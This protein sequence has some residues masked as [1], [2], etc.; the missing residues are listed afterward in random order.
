MKMCL[1]LFASALSV[2]V[3]SG[4]YADDLPRAVVSNLAAIE[5]LLAQVPDGANWQSLRPDLQ[6]SFRGRALLLLDQDRQSW[7]LTGLQQKL[8]K[9]FND[10]T[11][12]MTEN[13]DRILSVTFAPELPGGFKMA[14]DVSSAELKRLLIRIYLAITDDRG[15][16]LYN[17]PDFMGWD[18]M[19]IKEL[20]LL[21][22]EH[23]RAIAT[24]LRLTEDGLRGLPDD[25]LSALERALRDKSY[26]TT[27][28][29]KNFDRPAVGI[30]GSMNFSNLYALDPQKRPFTNDTE[31]LDAYNASMFSEFREVN[32]GTLDAFMY[33][34]ESEFNQPLLASQGMA[35]TLA[36][37][38]VKLGNLFRSRV[39]AL[40]E[41]S[42]R[43]MIF[44]PV[45][46][47][48]HWDAFTA[49]LISNADGSDSMRG[50]ADRFQATAAQRLMATQSLGR[51]MLERF[52]PDGSA[53]LTAEQRKRVGDKLLQER[54]PAKIKD[55]L[56]AALDEATGNASASRK[57]SDA[58]DQQPRVGGNY[59]DGQAVREDDKKQ[60]VDMWSKI[61][62]F[63]KREYSGYRV[64]ISTL[65]PAEPIIVTK[66]QNQYTLGGQVTL[67]LGTGWNLA[68]LSSTMMH[69]I[70][71]AIDQNSHTAVEG[72]AWEGA[73]TS[74]ERQV[75]PI[76][77]EEAMAGQGAL[78]PA[79][80][81]KTE[82]DNVRFTATT[83]A[84]LKIF[85]RESCRDDEPDTIA[86]AEGI[87]RDYG[88]D[89]EEI[90]RLRSRRAHRSWQYLEYDYGLAMYTDLLGFLQ[91][92]VGAQPRVDAYLLQA[93]G[94]PSAKKEQA[95]VDQL[96]ACIRDRKN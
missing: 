4:A 43:C 26:F 76:F 8:E 69:E 46:Q 71:H 80:R 62:A 91:Q 35:E 21:D 56:L 92:G 28:A 88:Y 13:V 54:R 34:Y 50:Y 89:D 15:Y 36:G 41:K 72:A 58:F 67:S 87:V 68:S 11:P 55:A 74:I 85:L 23:V 73:A 29:G 9:L 5:Q 57:V 31:L 27:R 17:H 44:S 14:R 47:D 45:E 95:T 83:D 63:I 81:L 82:I 6:A 51:S 96:K 75:W 66:G 16:I 53:E 93:C 49:S 70:K 77:I 30:N 33:D 3:E 38:I 32:M 61:R 60:I 79:A 12:A 39:H 90:L 65:V 2:I 22:H 94:L 7:G 52:F 59:S 24:W 37:N 86:Y 40:P 10:P 48:V 25:K 84:T 18:G 19:P 78:L 64:D 20:Q 1:A 42:L